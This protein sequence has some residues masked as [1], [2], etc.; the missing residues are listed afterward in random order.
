[1]ALPVFKNVF[2]RSWWVMQSHVR[3]RVGGFSVL[4]S[5]RVRL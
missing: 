2:R 3:Y 5:C 4:G 1:V